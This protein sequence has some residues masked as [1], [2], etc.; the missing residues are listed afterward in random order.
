MQ[1]LIFEW[2]NVAIENDDNDDDS[3]SGVCSNNG[4]PPDKMLIGI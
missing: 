2:L 3:D 4:M 1:I